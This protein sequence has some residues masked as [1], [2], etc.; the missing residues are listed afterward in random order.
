MLTDGAERWPYCLLLRLEIM[1]KWPGIVTQNINSDPILGSTIM[2]CGLIW[3]LGIHI[4][5]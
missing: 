1:V 5:K 2:S 4:L 3:R